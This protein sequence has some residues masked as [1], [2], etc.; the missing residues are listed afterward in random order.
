MQKY[1]DWPLWTGVVYSGH[2]LV[3]SGH[4]AGPQWQLCSRRLN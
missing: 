1:V 4:H 2:R 3:H